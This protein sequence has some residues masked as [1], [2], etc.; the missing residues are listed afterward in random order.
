MTNKD[1]KDVV[2]HLNRL[3]DKVARQ[4]TKID[5]LDARL[6]KLIQTSD[7]L[8][9]IDNSK[10]NL[11]FGID[12]SNDLRQIIDKGAIRVGDKPLHFYHGG[13]VPPLTPEM[14]DRVGE[15]VR[16]RHEMMV[17]RAFGLPLDLIAPT[18]PV[19]MVEACEALE[20]VGIAV[21]ARIG[22]RA[23][24]LQMGLLLVMVVLTAVLGM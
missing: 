19:S 23:K 4:E 20:K 7:H 21:E 10:V 8:P 11:T 16:E 1:D 22:R 15:S 24:V 5:D 14:M 13:F 2:V 3:A 18:P 9:R 6:K 17:A 12:S